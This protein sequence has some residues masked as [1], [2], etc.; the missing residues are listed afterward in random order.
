MEE[1]IFLFGI[2]MPSL[3]SPH[4]SVDITITT[5][6]EQKVGTIQLELLPFILDVGEKAAE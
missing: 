6:N 3:L 2:V 4:S 5:D 1:I